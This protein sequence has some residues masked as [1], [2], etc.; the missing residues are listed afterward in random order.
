MQVSAAIVKEFVPRDE[1]LVD[2]FPGA[3]PLSDR[4]KESRGRDD[5]T[6]VWHGAISERPEDKRLQNEVNCRRPGANRCR[7][8]LISGWLR[9][10]SLWVKAMSF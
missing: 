2:G 8:Q 4:R 3:G 1:M 10:T 7:L 5:D 6:S 9:A